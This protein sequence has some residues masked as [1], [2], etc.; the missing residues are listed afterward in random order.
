M[1]TLGEQS[2]QLCLGKKGKLVRIKEFG[3]KKQQI[4]NIN[5]HVIEKL[6]PKSIHISL[7][8]VRS[9]SGEI[10]S[11]LHHLATTTHMVY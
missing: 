1:R 5:Y 7:T 10:T 9:S 6:R 11:E 4:G 3:T 8:S 2:E